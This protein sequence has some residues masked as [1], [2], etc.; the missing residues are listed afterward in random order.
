MLFHHKSTQS[1]Q[2]RSVGASLVFSTQ[3]IASSAVY[4]SS[5]YPWYKS[6]LVVLL[7]KTGRY[8]VVQLGNGLFFL[9][10]DLKGYTFSL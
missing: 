3:S 4:V 2:R 6:T 5:L 9:I 8:Q 1:S 10:P 7:K